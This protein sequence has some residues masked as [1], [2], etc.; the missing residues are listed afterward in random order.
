MKVWR[1]N[2][3]VYHIVIIPK[4]PCFTSSNKPDL[5]TDGHNQGLPRRRGWTEQRFRLD[6]D[7]LNSPI[8]FPTLLQ[9]VF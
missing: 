9:M 1:V 8:L 3:S 6:C 7:F 4:T 2:Y 5:M